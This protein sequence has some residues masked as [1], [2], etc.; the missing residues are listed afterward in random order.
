MTTHP[1]CCISC[2]GV[3]KILNNTRENTKLCVCVK[4]D[5]MRK[6]KQN[7]W[8]KLI[9]PRSQ[10]FRGVNRQFRDSAVINQWLGSQRG[11][12]RWGWE[13]PVGLCFY[14]GPWALSLRL[15]FRGCKL[16]SI[17]KTCMKGEF[18]YMDLLLTIKFYRNQPLCIVEFGLVR[19]GTCRL[20]CK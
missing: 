16:A 19:W 7:A 1:A 12:K 11:R 5:T 3:L 8:N 9:T 6:W 2:Q 13:G 14:W 20:Y 18:I 10:E 15:F 4:R 17:K